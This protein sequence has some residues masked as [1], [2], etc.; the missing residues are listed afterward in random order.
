M[1]NLI[2]VLKSD[3]FTGKQIRVKELYPR[4]EKRQ[5]G[6]ARRELVRV[7]KARRGDKVKLKKNKRI[8][9]GQ[10]EMEDWGVLQSSG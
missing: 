2:H 10:R 5:G 4:D 8:Y 9:K 6:K 3:I 1:G 7:A